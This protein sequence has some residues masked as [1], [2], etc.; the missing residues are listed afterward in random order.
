MERICSAPPK[1]EPLNAST[2]ARGQDL[3]PARPSSPLWVDPQER[4]DLHAGGVHVWRAALDGT[5]DRVRSMREILDDEERRR[6][7]RLGTEQARRRFTVGRGLLRMILGRYLEV[8]PGTLRFT[9][10]PQGKPALADLSSGIPLHFNV[11]HSGDLVVY[12]ATLGRRIGVDVEHLRQGFGGERIAERFF[13][14]AEIAALRSISDDEKGRAFFNCWTRKEAYIKATG[15]SILRA[16]DS[17]DVSLAPGEPAALLRAHG[18]PEEAG[19]W[20]LRE[21]DVGAEYVAALAVEGHGWSLTC[22]QWP[23]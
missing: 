7:D 22:W 5:P 10:G 23:A 2:P 3:K 16:L 17:F 11:A 19:R 1:N 15:A 18:D 8:D 20:S 9:Y 13:S 12:A 6:V 14:A 21:L 4:L